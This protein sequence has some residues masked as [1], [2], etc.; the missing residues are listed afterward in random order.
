VGYQ[1]RGTQ[2]VRVGLWS[3]HLSRDD[4][5]GHPFGLGR[6]QDIGRRQLVGVC[7]DGWRP[8][9][10]T[11]VTGSRQI[12]VA[13]QTRRRFRIVGPMQRQNIHRLSD[14]RINLTHLEVRLCRR[15]VQRWLGD[16]GRGSS[17]RHA[18]GGTADRVCTTLGATGPFVKGRVI[19]GGKSC[20]FV[21]D[22]S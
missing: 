10:Q 20:A 21:M 7:C 17:A 8:Q 15:L 16:G 3:C 6:H 5:T 22:S 12:G 14:R 19:S 2:G 4:G 11:G 18:S 13:R 9:L 1:G